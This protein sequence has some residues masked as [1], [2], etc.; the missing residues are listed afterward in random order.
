MRVKS[1]AGECDPN[2]LQ[3]FYEALPNRFE[4]SHAIRLYM[5]TFWKC[6]H[7]A[8][9]DLAALHQT[10]KLIRYKLSTDKRKNVY[11]KIR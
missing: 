7:I 4:G 3:R 11:E 6:D 1:Y 10:G 8:Y 9:R 2:R 5:T